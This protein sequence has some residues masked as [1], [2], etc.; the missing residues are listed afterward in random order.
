M[1]HRN[2]IF[3]LTFSVIAFLSMFLIFSFLTKYKVETYEKNLK[4]Y[5]KLSNCVV[6]PAV[7][8]KALKVDL[9]AKSE[10]KEV[11][12]T[13]IISFLAA[14]YFGDWRQYQETDLDEIARK[15]YEG[16]REED[17]VHIYN[18]YWYFKDFYEALFSQ[19]VGEYDISR[20]IG[21]STK[22]EDVVFEQKYG[23]KVYSPIAYGYKI[24]FCDD[25]DNEVNF[26]KQKGHFGNDIAVKI[27]TPFVAVESGIIDRIH[28]DGNSYLL[29]L[30]SLDGKRRYIYSNC[31]EKKP[32]ANGIKKGTI[33][34]GGQ[35]LGFVGCGNCCD[36]G[37][38]KI[39][40]CPYLH[41]AIKLSVGKENESAG[42]IYIDA[43]NILRF[44]EHHKAE[45][46]KRQGDFYSKH[47][48]IENKKKK[49]IQDY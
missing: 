9:Q 6:P 42:E 4:Q 31:S 1:R 29:E 19:F 2:K 11:K 5:K 23:L 10:G 16:A 13:K 49:R 27:G 44:L 34:S 20:T 24:S 25:F 47:I 26:A 32:F 21:D 41:F 15:F 7:M 38:A 39:L 18:N 3:M 46:Y 33:V 28:N 37:G 8:E 45:L 43:Y 35:L 30:K 22:K 17:L 40:N 36:K 12:F 48:Y 14:K